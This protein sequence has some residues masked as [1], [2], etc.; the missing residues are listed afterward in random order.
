MTTKHP[1]T[2]SSCKVAR[3]ATVP[4]PYAACGPTA[5]PR[6]RRPAQDDRCDIFGEQRGQVDFRDQPR[7]NA[8]RCRLAGAFIDADLRRPSIAEYMGVE[9]EVGV[10]TML[11]GR[12]A[13]QD[14]R[15]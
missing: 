7:H 9:G 13:V 10:T 4:W 14:A 1:N 2:R 6:H 8:G 11:M 5:V 12:A 3:T 15:Q